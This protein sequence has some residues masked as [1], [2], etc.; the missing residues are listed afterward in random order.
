MAN[1]EIT[2]KSITIVGSKKIGFKAQAEL[3]ACGTCNNL[4]V[5]IELAIET[6]E[7]R[8]Y[9]VMSSD[10]ALT[11]LKAEKDKLDLG[12]I[13]QEQYDNRKTELAKFIK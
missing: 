11:A 2:V 3:A 5:D 6:K 12:L 7:V 10:E 13:T 9:G 4:L 8:P 1:T